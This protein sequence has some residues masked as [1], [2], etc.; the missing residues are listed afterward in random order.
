MS[1]NKLQRAEV[2]HVIVSGSELL[3][4]ERKNDVFIRS[5]LDLGSKAFGSEPSSLRKK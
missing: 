2:I 4:A 5:V 1:G 3:S